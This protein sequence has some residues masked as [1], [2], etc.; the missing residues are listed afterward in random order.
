MFSK[1][2]LT[3]FLLFLFNFYIIA[4][5]IYL[6][7][8]E[9]NLFSKEINKFYFFSNNNNI[10]FVYLDKDM[11]LKISLIEYREENFFIGNTIFLY[12]YHKEDKILYLKAFYNK[13]IYYVIH[14]EKFSQKL[15][16]TYFDNRLKPKSIIISNNI[17]YPE[18]FIS[19]DTLNL[20]YISDN[21]IFCK[22]IYLKNFKE[23]IIAGE[24][25]IAFFKIVKNNNLYGMLWKFKDKKDYLYFSI[26]DHRLHG[27]SKIYKIVYKKDI[28]PCFVFNDN[29]FSLIFNYNKTIYSFLL[30]KGDREIIKNNEILDIFSDKEI[31]DFVNIYNK[32]VIIFKERIEIEKKKYIDILEVTKC[33]NNFNLISSF[34]PRKIEGVLLEYQ[35]FVIYGK[36]FLFIIDSYQNSLKYVKVE[37]W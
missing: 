2:K 16:L 27:F 15:I 7:I 32:N 30:E 20:F 28:P 11:K 37:D 3:F 29:I 14:M 4:E 9:F 12:N 8:N 5:D 21:R 36:L 24:K 17:S 13:G 10:F 23:K 35:F 33:D 26:I 18:V 19:D 34:L 6:K 1:K 25:N 22:K 31:I